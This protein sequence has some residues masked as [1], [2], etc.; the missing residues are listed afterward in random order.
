MSINTT[1][2]HHYI[3]SSRVDRIGRFSGFFLR[4]SVQADIDNTC[5][6]RIVLCDNGIVWQGEV[7]P[8]H[9]ID[10]E[11]M[12]YYRRATLTIHPEGKR[13]EGTLHITI[14]RESKK[15]AKRKESKR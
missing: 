2:I 12:K 13:A 1:Y 6:I 4:I 10:V 9:I 11:P 8:G 15:R 14:V 3:D 7:E 5:T